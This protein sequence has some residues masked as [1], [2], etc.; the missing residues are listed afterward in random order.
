M[1]LIGSNETKT[2][3]HHTQ[4]IAIGN[5]GINH[6]NVNR[7]I[8][9]ELKLLQDVNYFYV[10]QYDKQL[11]I[12]IVP[13]AILA[14]RPERC[15]LNGTL[16][17]A[18]N[19]TRRW[20]YSSLVSP[21]KLASCKICAYHRINDYFTNATSS[22]RRSDICG[23]CCD[24][25]FISTSKAAE[26][27]PPRDYPRT[28]HVDSPSFP[29]DRDV[30]DNNQSRTLKPMKMTY[31]ILIDGT[32]AAAFNL[33]TNH[34]KKT[35]TRCYL[36]T[37][38]VSSNIIDDIFKNVSEC[39]RNNQSYK[40]FIDKLDLPYT[41]NDESSVLD[42]FIETPMHHLFEGIVKSLI[43]VTMDYLKFYKCWRKYC[44]R[45]NPILEDI[46]SLKL[47]FCNAETFWHSKTDFKATGW[48]ADNYLGYARIIVILLAHMDII[49]QEE[50]R[51]ANEFNA[52][53]QTS[54]V[55]ISHL[56]T[57][58]HVDVQLINDLIKIFLWSCHNFDTTFG[59]S[60]GNIPF[61]YKKSNFVSLLN[62]PTQIDHYGPVYLYWE[63][64]KERYIQYVK[65]ILKNKRKTASYLCTK[66]QQLLRNNA[67]EMQNNKYQL[68][69][70]KFYKRFQIIYV[71]TN[72]ITLQ[73]K[74][75]KGESLSILIKQN[76][77]PEYLTIVKFDNK[78]N[79]FPIVFDDNYGFHKC[80]LWFAPIC[81]GEKHNNEYSDIN[82]ICCS[83][84]TF[85]ILVCF[86]LNEKE[87]NTRAD[88]TL[89]SSNWLIRSQ[90]NEM[91]LPTV[92]RD[93]LETITI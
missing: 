45:I 7:K 46:N 41:W 20:L 53:I 12:V 90:S 82:D 2:S 34:W 9:C 87:E 28:K 30:L 18:G 47:E 24:F 57:R 5:K 33:F 15:T 13:I 29:S 10:R 78:Y 38:G 88:Y 76:D 69:T 39:N 26:F 77:P 60:D 25:D 43:E 48:I 93:I 1:T 83:D 40:S 31:E 65:P 80:N 19:S 63:G 22:I 62:L 49:I 68:S 42:Q 51:A 14:D 86:L 52:M 54:F 56:M 23:R 27:L 55:L 8:N 32:K 11:P 21:T 71:Y 72:L 92:S 79:C 50:R 84:D 81:L 3:R 70:G 74:I 59:Y 89:V 35:E 85:G 64:V 17:F 75:D 73:Q 16:S 58:V 91:K 37:L 66:A 61:W 6:N 67:L 4:L 44:E 36:K